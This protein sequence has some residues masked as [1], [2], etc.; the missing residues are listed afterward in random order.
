MMVW[1]VRVVAQQG[2][3]IYLIPEIVKVLDSGALFGCDI[4]TNPKNLFP[5]IGGQ[6]GRLIPGVRPERGLRNLRH[7]RWG[8]DWVYRYL[9][10]RERLT[11]VGE[12]RGLQR[13]IGK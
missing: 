1:K 4:G 6:S 5:P 10:A 13:A 11:R 8:I 12:A 7:E 9:V 3:G 2:G